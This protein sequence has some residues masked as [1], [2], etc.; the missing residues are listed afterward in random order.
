MDGCL[1]VGEE[2]PPPPVVEEP[3]PPPPPPVEDAP[4][5]L[6]FDDEETTTAVRAG[7][8][9]G[10]VRQLPHQLAWQAC[11][12]RKPRNDQRGNIAHGVQHSSKH[13]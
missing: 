3:P 7:C 10:L 1:Q 13:C 8:P 2:E 6:S 11:E 12:Q 4:D 9:R 5:L